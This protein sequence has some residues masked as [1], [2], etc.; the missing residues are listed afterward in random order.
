MVRVMKRL[1]L[2]SILALT[3]FANAGTWKYELQKNDFDGDRKIALLSP[4][5]SELELMITNEPSS[6]VYFLLPKG[7]L[8]SSDCTFCT[9]RVIADGQEVEPIKVLGS[10]N[11]KTYYLYSPR[12]RFIKL[13]EENKVVKI[14]LPS[15]QGNRNLTFTQK[16]KLDLNKLNNAK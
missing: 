3:S 1:I 7:F 9:A 4:D 13:F 2:A 16:E 14:Q 12:D 15:F 8:T 10:K 11:F 6:G 5:D